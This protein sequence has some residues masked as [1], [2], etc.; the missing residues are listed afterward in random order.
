MATHTLSITLPDTL[1][2]FV[3]ECVAH[4]AYRDTSDYVGG[5]IQQDQERRENMTAAQAELEELLLEGLQSGEPVTANP[6]YWRR[7]RA[8]LLAAATRPG[9]ET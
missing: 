1:K 9:Q 6:E 2:Q 8:E 5:L 7:T 3:D 4:G